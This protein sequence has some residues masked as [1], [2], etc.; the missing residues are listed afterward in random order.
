MWTSRTRRH[1]MIDDKLYKLVGIEAA[2]KETDKGKII[3]EALKKY[4]GGGERQ[5]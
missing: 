1:I 2:K 4:F 3:E 5:E